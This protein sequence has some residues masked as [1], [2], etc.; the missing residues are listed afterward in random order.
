M[1][2]ILVRS[3]RPLTN[4]IREARRSAGGTKGTRDGNGKLAMVGGLFRVGYRHCF[5]VD[6]NL[7]CTVRR[8][9]TVEKEKQEN[10]RE[11]ERGKGGRGRTLGWVLPCLSVGGGV[12]LNYPLVP[13][14]PGDVCRGAGALALPP[15][16]GGLLH[17]YLYACTATRTYTYTHE[18]ER[19]RA[20][21]SYL[22]RGGVFN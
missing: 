21:A 3:I 4:G 8:E 15:V 20:R 14:L 18:C 5:T 6:E 9:E 7:I 10:E 22:L 16:V 11:R 12:K 13:R 2:S 19:E 17:R 1:R